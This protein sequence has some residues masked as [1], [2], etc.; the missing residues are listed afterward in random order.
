M[1]EYHFGTT[2][3]IHTHTQTDRQPT[4]KQCTKCHMSP[5]CRRK[6]TRHVHED[7]AEMLQEVYRRKCEERNFLRK[8]QACYKKYVSIYIF[9]D[10][11]HRQCRSKLTVYFLGAGLERVGA[12]I[13]IVSI[14]FYCNEN[15][16][17]ARLQYVRLCNMH[18]N[19]WFRTEKT[20]F[21]R[22]LRAALMLR[23][24]TQ[25]GVSRTI[26]SHK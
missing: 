3:D 7:G 19:D 11:C 23:M 5:F 15:W 21:V 14:I 2:E 4:M 17:L 8:C 25:F 24:N 13:S 6:G 20:E 16:L 22:I 10:A 1:T 9:C 26:Q 12:P 18:T